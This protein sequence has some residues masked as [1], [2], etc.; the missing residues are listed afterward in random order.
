MRT[1]AETPT[2]VLICHEEERLDRDGLASWL[3]S[4]MRLAGLLIIR[5]EPCRRWRAARRELKRV[6]PLGLLDVAAFRAYARLRHGRR[7][8]QW[9]DAEIDAPAPPL[10][11][12]TSVVFRGPTSRHRTPLRPGRSSQGV[13]PDLAIARCKVL[14]KPDD[15][16]DPESRARLS[17]TPASARS[18][19]TLMAASGRWR[20]ATSIASA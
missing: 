3:A 19:A 18:T 11:R 4:T 8:A 6:G 5:D 2:V 13:A 20:T 9:Q 10:S 16:R 17:C 14:L 7:D 15:L 12:Q 1:H